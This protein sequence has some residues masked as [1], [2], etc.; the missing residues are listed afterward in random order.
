MYYGS[1]KHAV[2]WFGRLGYTLPYGINAADFILD[3][4][5]SDVATD[6]RHTLPPV[7]QLNAAEAS[8]CCNS[9]FSIG[10]L[11][12]YIVRR[13]PDGHPSLCTLIEWTA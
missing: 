8:C 3:L 6:K 12:D 4:A 7:S 9:A 13:Q 11:L 1:A 2:D 10:F 5:S